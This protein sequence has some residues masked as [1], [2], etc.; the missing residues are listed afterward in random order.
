MS[1]SGDCGANYCRDELEYVPRRCNRNP[2]IAKK[3]LGDGAQLVKRALRLIVLARHLITTPFLLL[4]SII[5]AVMNVTI[6]INDSARAR[7]DDDLSQVS[8][9]KLDLLESRLYF[10]F[11]GN[12]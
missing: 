4:P 7:Q 3:L 5:I 2:E 1:R 11:N 12:D 9:E 8:N 6:M 10:A